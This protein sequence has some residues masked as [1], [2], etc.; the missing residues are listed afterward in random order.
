MVTACGVSIPSLALRQSRR[1]DRKGHAVP[2]T[3][4][5]LVIRIGEDTPALR[6]FLATSFAKK[7]M[8][9][10]T[11]RFDTIDAAD[12]VVDGFDYGDGWYI[13]AQEIP[14]SS[15]MPGCGFACYMRAVV[16][17]EPND[18][19]DHCGTYIVE[20]QGE[21]EYVSGSE[22]RTLALTLR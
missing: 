3:E 12:L 22:V 16:T 5:E 19:Y 9:S 4:S 8:L 21:V 15:P 20:C 2:E 1:T 10:D 13:M 7:P 11:Q 6:A 18:P 17:F 14:T